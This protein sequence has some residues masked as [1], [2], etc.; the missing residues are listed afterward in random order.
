[1]TGGMIVRLIDV[2]LIILFGFIGISDIQNKTQIKLPG[3]TQNAPVQSEIVT[4][5]VLVAIEPGDYYEITVQ[6]EGE[7]GDE[8]FPVQSLANLRTALQQLSEQIRSESKN[9]VVI[10]DPREN[11]SMQQTIDVFDMCEEEGYAKSIDFNLSN[12]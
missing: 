10:I 12:S 8:P 9:M 5:T 2:V 11:A 3:K 6:E 7:E 4:V 1:M